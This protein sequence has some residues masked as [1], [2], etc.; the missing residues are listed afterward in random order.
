MTADL[1]SP[2]STSQP[3]LVCTSTSGQRV[4]I[5]VSGEVD[6]SSAASLRDQIVR[7]V[8]QRP[9]SLVVD[10]TDL[11]FCDLRGLD[12][13]HDAMALAARSGVDLT[14]RP[15]SQLTWLMATVARAAR[16]SGRSGPDPSGR[17]LA[18]WTG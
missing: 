1:R 7:T 4:V 8:T 13:I 9:A 14:L 11:S 10:A 5:A 6:A 3:L 15:S 12:A 17:P 2:A 16:T 18:R